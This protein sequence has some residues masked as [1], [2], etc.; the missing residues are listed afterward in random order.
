[1]KR[2]QLFFNKALGLGLY[3]TSYLAALS[4]MINRLSVTIPAR[5]GMVVSMGQNKNVKLITIIII[6]Y[7][8]ACNKTLTKAN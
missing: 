6:S 1:L 8:F 4:G 3:T 7:T 5:L 2:Q